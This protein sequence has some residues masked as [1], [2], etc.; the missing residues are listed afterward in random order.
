MRSSTLSL[1]FSTLLFTLLPLSSLAASLPGL[2]TEYS[3]TV[4]Y[5]FGTLGYTLSYDEYYSKS[6]GILRTDGRYDDRG[7]IEL[8]QYNNNGNVTFKVV[9]P[10]ALT[11]CTAYSLTAAQNAS[12]LYAPAYSLFQLMNYSG[13]TFSNQ[14]YSSMGDRQV[15]ATYWTTPTY[16]LSS[17]DIFCDENNLCDSTDGSGTYAMPPWDL[18]ELIDP[19]SGYDTSSYSV[20]FSLAVYLQTQGQRLHHAV[21]HLCQRH[22]CQPQQQQQRSGPVQQH[23]RRHTHTNSDTSHWRHLNSHH[24]RIASPCLLC[25]TITSLLCLACSRQL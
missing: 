17:D 1:L 14:G 21:A 3:C 7:V 8:T 23:V 22:A 2:P 4:E 5:N 24:S 9:D 11:P 20:T 15:N 19:A 12:L 25:L 16:T 10:S 13:W 18:L 6:L